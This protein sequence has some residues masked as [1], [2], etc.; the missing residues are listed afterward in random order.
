MSN[1]DLAYLLNFLQIEVPLLMLA[2]VRTETNK[3]KRDEWRVG[4]N[5]TVNLN[6]DARHLYFTLLKNYDK[7]LEELENC[8]NQSAN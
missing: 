1:A 8:V 3:G 7:E 5:G 2:F 6:G 4:D